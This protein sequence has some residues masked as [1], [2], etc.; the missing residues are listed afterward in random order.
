MSITPGN[1]PIAR[2]FFALAVKY[3][4][5]AIR[6]HVDEYIQCYVRLHQITEEIIG[7]N[8]QIKVTA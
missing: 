3:H 4:N 5:L 7:L 2:F 6:E 1:D 8:F